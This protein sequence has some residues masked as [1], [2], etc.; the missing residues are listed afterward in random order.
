MARRRAGHP[1]DKD[2][3]YPDKTRTQLDGPLLRA[4]T[5]R[6][7]EPGVYNPAI[8][9]SHASS[10]IT[11]TPCFC[12][13][14]SFEPAPGPAT[15]RSVLAETEPDTLAPKDSARALASW[16]VIFSSEPVKTTVL[17][18]TG[19]PSI[20]RAASGTTVTSLRRL[21]TRRTL[22]GSSKKSL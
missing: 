14:L 13:S 15:T 5:S 17:P 2:S 22:C 8:I 18:A 3:F 20:L 6:G 9:L 21:A 10:S 12:A 1:G 11:V 19:E 4:M 16:R 7:D